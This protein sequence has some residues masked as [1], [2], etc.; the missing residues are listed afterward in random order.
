MEQISLDPPGAGL[1]FL[2]ALYLRHWLAP[3]HSRKKSNQENLKNFLHETQK[4][5]ALTGSMDASRA[6]NRVLIDRIPG[7]EDSSR[8]WSIQMTLEHLVIVSRAMTG[9]AISLHKGVVPNQAVRTDMVKPAGQLP[10]AD[11]LAAF[12]QLLE[13]IPSQLGSVTERSKLTHN[14]PWFGAFDSGQWIWILATHQH[15]HRKQVQEILSRLS[16]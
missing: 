6:E 14:H 13:E 8:H 16:A 15:L 2:E 9:I 12:R 7:L 5:I 11:T 10:W 3:R 1:P 4:I